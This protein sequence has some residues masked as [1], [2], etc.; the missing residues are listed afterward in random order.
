MP[1]Q[2]AVA[3]NPMLPDIPA[4]IEFAKDERTRQILRLVLAPLDMDRPILAPPGIPAERMAALRTAF[5]AAMQ[6]PTFLAE[7]QQHRLEIG[8]ISGARIAELLITAFDLPPEVVKAASDAMNLTGS[9][10][11]K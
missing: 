2:V 8:E 9:Q 1:I 10:K 7:A 11:A 3:R 4:V 5:H 6:D